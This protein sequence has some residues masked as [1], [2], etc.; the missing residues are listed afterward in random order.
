MINQEIVSTFVMR[1]FDIPFIG[2][3]GACSTFGLATII[4]SLFIFLYTLKYMRTLLEKKL[5]LRLKTKINSLTDNYHLSFFFGIIFTFVL[6]SSS[7]LTAII[8]T[9]LSAKIISR[10]QKKAS[11]LPE[12]SLFVYKFQFTGQCPVTMRAQAGCESLR[13][14]VQLGIDFASYTRK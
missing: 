4:G 3:Y 11:P 8:I 13:Q 1:D 5:S 14:R 7:A 2:L 10:F 6:S 9:F 12:S